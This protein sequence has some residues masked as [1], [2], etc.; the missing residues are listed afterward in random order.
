MYEKRS[1]V[2]LAIWFSITKSLEST[3]TWIVQVECNTPLE[4]SQGNLQV[5]FRSHPNRRSK[6]GVMSCQNLESPNQ[7]NF[8]SPLWESWEKVPFGWRCYGVTQR[9]LYGGRWWLPPSPS[10]DERVSPRLLVTCLS[11]ASASEWELTNL[12][13]GLMHIWV[14]K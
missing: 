3:Q 10:R 9:I 4:S 1:G 8:E 13:V 2:K 5:C 6:L 7:N 14:T 12:L 11:I